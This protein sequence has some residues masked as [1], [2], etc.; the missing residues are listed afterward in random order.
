MKSFE[1]RIKAN[2]LRTVNLVSTSASTAAPGCTGGQSHARINMSCCLPTQHTTTTTMRRRS[3]FIGP[4][5][6]WGPIFGCPSLWHVVET[7][8]M[9]LWLM[10][11]PNGEPQS[12]ARANIS[13]CLLTNHTRMM[14]KSKTFIG[15]RQWGIAVWLIYWRNFTYV[16]SGGFVPSYI[17]VINKRQDNTPHPPRLRSAWLYDIGFFDVVTKCNWGII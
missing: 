2:R 13:S 8:L 11:T 10:K 14:R 7:F 5:W 16:I 15:P 9:R 17:I 4:R 3:T 1:M 6:T 12:L